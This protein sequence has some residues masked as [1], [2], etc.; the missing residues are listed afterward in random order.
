M[1]N[2]KTLFVAALALGFVAPA[3]AQTAPESSVF[4]WTHDN[5]AQY[6]AAIADASKNVLLFVGSAANFAYDRRELEQLA[7]EHR[8]LF[9]VYADPD[10]TPEAKVELDHWVEKPQTFPTA[11][12]I[13]DVVLPISLSLPRRNGRRRDC[14]HGQGRTWSGR[15]S[16]RRSLE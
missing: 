11:V 9:V 4:V 5:T 8:D 2:I 1:I 10:Q 16:I 15:V 3:S 14:R 13:G 7:R 6:S 12:F